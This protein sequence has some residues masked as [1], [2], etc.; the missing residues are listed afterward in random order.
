[1]RFGE[2]WKTKRENSRIMKDDE[3]RPWFAWYPVRV[4]DD[5]TWVWLENVEYNQPMKYNLADY[6]LQRS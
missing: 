4:V 5:F 1:M 2:P 3:W 6:R